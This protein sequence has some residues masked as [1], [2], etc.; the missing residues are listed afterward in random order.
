MKDIVNFILNYEKQLVFIKSAIYAMIAIGISIVSIYSMTLSI[1]PITKA[2]IVLFG[3]L[4][5]LLFFGATIYNAG[6]RQ[7]YRSLMKGEEIK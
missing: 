2:M 3:S 4:T 6:L 1:S 5:A 7:S